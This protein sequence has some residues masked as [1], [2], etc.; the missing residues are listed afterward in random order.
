MTS[1]ID[2]DKIIVAIFGGFQNSFRAW[3]YER[4][5]RCIHCSL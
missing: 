5:T 2:L 1:F 3:I 4:A